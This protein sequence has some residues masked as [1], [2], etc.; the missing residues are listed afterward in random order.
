MS[1]ESGVL[2][3]MVTFHLFGCFIGSIVTAIN[4]PYLLIL[5]AFLGFRLRIK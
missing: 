1:S 5:I 4:L 3:L 2:S